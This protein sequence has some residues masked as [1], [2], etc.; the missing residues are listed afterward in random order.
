MEWVED[1][2]PADDFEGRPDECR[3][4]E[5]LLLDQHEDAKVIR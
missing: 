4:R 5:P 1:D 2:D 3:R